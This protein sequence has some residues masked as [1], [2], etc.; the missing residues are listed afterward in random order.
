MKGLL[1]YN[2]C[3]IG[4]YHRC[5]MCGKHINDSKAWIYREG[6]I[7]LFFCGD[8]NRCRDEFLELNNLQD[9]EEEE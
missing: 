2:A 1:F 5:N 6:D 3:V 9:V 8:T 7:I 4:S